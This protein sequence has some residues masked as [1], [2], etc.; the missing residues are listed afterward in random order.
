VDAEVG[1]AE[2]PPESAFDDGPTRRHLVRIPSLPKRMRA[3]V[4]TTPGLTAFAMEAP[5]V[6]VEVGYRHPIPPRAWP[7]M[8]ELAGMV[9][10]RGRGH[11]AWTIDRVPAFGDVRALAKVDVRVEAARGAAVDHAK[12]SELRVPVKAA[13]REVTAAQIA[14]K[15]VP[16]VKRLAYALP[17]SMLARATIARTTHGAFVRSPAGMGALLLGAPYVE[18]HP[19]V[20]LAAGHEVAPAVAPEVLARALDVPESCT[21]FLSADGR[22]IAIEDRAFVRLEDAIAAA[23][24]IELAEGRA[25]DE[26]LAAARID[27][28]LVPLG[29]FPLAGVQLEKG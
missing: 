13:W 11:V 26:T 12:M 6:G 22:A 15:D 28:D 10:F 25:A 14:E 4:E 2:W 29:A 24:E 9:L 8:T 20:F 21:V 5:G 19:R 1:V 3:L 17:R 16:I 27:L 18:V 23:P 7:A